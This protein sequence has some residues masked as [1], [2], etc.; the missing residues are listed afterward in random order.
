[1]GFAAVVVDRV[2]LFED[3]LIVADSYLEFSAY[4]YVKLLTLMGMGVGDSEFFVNVGDSYEERFTYF[5]SELGGKAQVAQTL[6]SCDRQTLAL[7]CDV[8]ALDTGA[9][10][11][12]K[13]SDFDT[14]GI[15]KFVDER[16]AE[17]FSSALIGKVFIG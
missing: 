3:F 10:A 6:S 9:F 1:M 13:V 12:H 4:D 11:L 16:K 2:A 5:V 17:I 7:S 8:K 15:G 14:A